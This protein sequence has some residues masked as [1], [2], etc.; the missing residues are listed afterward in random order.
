M[1]ER[2]DKKTSG[3][4]SAE[5]LTGADRAALDKIINQFNACRG[6]N[7]L[8]IAAATN[9]VIIR[10]LPNMDWQMWIVGQ[11]SNVRTSEQFQLQQQFLPSERSVASLSFAK[12]GAI[13]LLMHEKIRAHQRGGEI[14]HQ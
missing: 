11:E 12:Q 4:L 14:R 1:S 9:R 10:V 7:D 2:I 6:W 8:L 13:T 3:P 5:H